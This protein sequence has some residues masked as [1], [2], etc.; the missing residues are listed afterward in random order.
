VPVRDVVLSFIGS[1]ALMAHGSQAG[2]PFFLK[3]Y[4]GD[5]DIT[6]KYDVNWLT[7]RQSRSERLE[8]EREAISTYSNHITAASAVKNILAI[9]NDTNQ[10]TLAPSPEG[11]IGGYPVR[12]NARGAKAILP[13][14]L[15]LKQATK[16]NEDAERFDGIEKIKADG[17][18]VY[19]DKTY[20][21]MKEL[22]Y[23]CKELPFDDIESRSKE[24]E[25]LINKLHH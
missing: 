14:E 13:K 10:Y 2:V 21:A 3:V 17:T 15:T 6:E 20:S 24:L 1:H 19:T 9:L 11:L 16:I 7:Q 8:K 18:I 12:I 4:S 23:D 25:M 22:G 5:R